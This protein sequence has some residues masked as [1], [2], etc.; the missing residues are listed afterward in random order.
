MRASF[1]IPVALATLNRAIAQGSVSDW[2]PAG[3]GESRGPCPMLNTL[4]NHG[5]LPREGRNFTLPTVKHALKTGVN[6][7]EEIAE[8]LYN[9]ALTTNPGPNTTTW[10][11]DT[12]ANHNILEH[13]ASLS[14]SDDYFTHDV[15]SFNATVYNQ[16][17]SYWTEDLI[18]IQMVAN[19]RLARM[20]ESV[21]HNPQFALSELAGAFSAGEGAGYMLV[22]G[23]KTA[24]T[25]R[26]DF[27]EY[28]FE[29]ERLPTELGWTTAEAVIS[30]HDLS[31]FS[32]DI[33]NAT[34]YE[35]LNSHR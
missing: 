9:F 17:R 30:R 2:H 11:L 1:I 3:P 32:D 6:V 24:K 13:D 16:T 12:L 15:I 8:L 10:G 14:R 34:S 35:A 25:A 29:H 23:N 28:F 18:N 21:Q 7:S 31:T 33:I 19:A 22:F 5:F 27:V 26:R 20:L 4:A